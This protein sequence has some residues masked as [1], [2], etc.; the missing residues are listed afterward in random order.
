MVDAIDLEQT[1]LHDEHVALGARMV[2][3]AG[4]SMPVQYP[5][6]IVKEHHAVRN[7]VGL[8]DVSHMG[9]FEVRGPQA[10]DMVQHLLTNDASRLEVGQA[11]YTVLTT[12]EG[13]ALDDCILYR[14]ADHYMVV[15]NAGN[16]DKDRA[17]FEKAAKGFD[18]EFR[19]WF[20][21][22]CR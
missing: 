3:F 21:C 18:V 9:E 2:P 7:A 22:Q 15:V 19:D 12:P 5:T 17:W 10:L 4:F 6:G 20:G 11:Q 8:F 14:F 16:L 13:A 1:P